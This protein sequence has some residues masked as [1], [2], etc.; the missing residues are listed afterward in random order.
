MRSFQELNLALFLAVAVAV[1]CVPLC[2]AQSGSPADKHAQKIEK[3]LSKYK[4]GTLLHLRVQQQHGMHGNGEHTLGRLIYLQQLGDEC[5]GDPPLQRCFQC[6]KGQGV[7]RGRLCSEAPHPHI[8]IPVAMAAKL[9]CREGIES[10]RLLPS[11]GTRHSH[12]QVRTFC[13]SSA[14]SR[15]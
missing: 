1:V 14:D 3:K 15:G 10:F 4:T 7:H 13:G 8:L 5:E 12:T 6:W 9:A 11:T 2:Q